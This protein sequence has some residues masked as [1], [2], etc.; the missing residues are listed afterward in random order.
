M[1]GLAA[2]RVAAGR[3]AGY[4]A[5]APH[6]KGHVLLSF[7]EKGPKLDRRGGRR[8]IFRPG[9]YWASPLV[10]PSKPGFVVVR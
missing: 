4:A 10:I 2:L 5:H 7:S 3:K 6:S 8:V 9:R 1:E